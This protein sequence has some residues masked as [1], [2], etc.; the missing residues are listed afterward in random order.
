MKKYERSRD[1]VFAE[2]NQAFDAVME[3]NISKMEMLFKTLRIEQEAFDWLIFSVGSVGMLKLFLRYGE[4]MH[5]RG[6]PLHPHHMTLLLN[7]TALLDQI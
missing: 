3:N 1:L 2:N 5:K 4:D 6:P 7:C